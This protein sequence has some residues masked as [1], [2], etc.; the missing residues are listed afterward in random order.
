MSPPER[1]CRNMLRLQEN[2][3]AAISDTTVRGKHCLRV[4]INNHR[5]RRS[6]LDLL[7]REILP[8]R[9]G[10]WDARWG[11]RVARSLPLFVCF[12]RRQLF[13]ISTPKSR[14]ASR[15]SSRALSADTGSGPT[16]APPM[17]HERH[18]VGDQQEGHTRLYIRLASH[19]S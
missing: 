14:R 17:T 2:G 3:V 12:L 8:P 18:Q 5:T 1:L 4:A 11:C 13:D 6:D 19:A 9:A 10:D 15:P 7:V 16:T